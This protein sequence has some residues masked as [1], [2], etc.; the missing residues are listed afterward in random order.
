V[1]IPD[2][3]AFQR[4]LLARNPALEFLDD[5]WSGVEAGP[6]CGSGGF[7]TNEQFLASDAVVAGNGGSRS[8]GGKVSPVEINIFQ[9]VGRTPSVAVVAV[10]V[11]LRLVEVN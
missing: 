5:C 10:V 4:I 2:H 9:I 8:E 1:A 6:S 11:S 7:K 3:E